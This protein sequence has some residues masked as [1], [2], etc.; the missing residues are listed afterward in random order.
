M[1][2]NVETF[3]GRMSKKDLMRASSYEVFVNPPVGDGQGIRLSAETVSLPGAS[4]MSVDNYKPYG[5]GKSHTIPYAGNL[6]AISMTH[7]VDAD[8]DIV[9]LFYDWT[10][11]IVD[12]GK[13]NDY[14]ARYL[15]TYTAKPLMI[16]LYDLK[17]NNT[18]TYNVQDAFPISV[19]QMQMSWGS[20]DEIL[21]LSVTYKFT[22]YFLVN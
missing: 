6:Q 17:G 19:D 14:L 15:N 11:S 5:L 18:K 13:N 20:S 1:A 7:M 9:Q 12:Y 10:N 3:K 8:N 16:F 4:F 21:K 2:F 22:E